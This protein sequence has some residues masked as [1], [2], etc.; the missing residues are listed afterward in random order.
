[1]RAGAGS[2][3]PG[4]L[5]SGSAPGRVSTGLPHI[6]LGGRIGFFWFITCSRQVM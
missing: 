3:K 4:P 1:M 2:G 6:G 5:P